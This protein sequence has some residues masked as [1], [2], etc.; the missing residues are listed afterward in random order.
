MHHGM[1]TSRNGPANRME[2]AAMAARRGLVPDPTST[3][4]LR[5]WSMSE[6]GVTNPFYARFADQVE[7]LAE[8]SP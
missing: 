4:S 3:T 1:R 6:T 7:I 8:A 2:A 5:D